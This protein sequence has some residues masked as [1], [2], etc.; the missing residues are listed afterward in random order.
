MQVSN[1]P[2][3]VSRQENLGRE[4]LQ[5][6]REQARCHQPQADG[7]EEIGR[8]NQG[9]GKACGLLQQ[10]QVAKVEESLVKT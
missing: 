6:E 9:D 10:R 2:E 8:Q 3:K 5:V 4:S 1:S 7:K